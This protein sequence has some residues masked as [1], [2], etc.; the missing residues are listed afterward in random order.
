MDS[1]WIATLNWNRLIFC[2]YYELWNFCW[3]Y[4]MLLWTPSFP[5]HGFKISVP[6]LVLVVFWQLLRRNGQISSKSLFWKQR[7]QRTDNSKVIS[8]TLQLTLVLYI[9]KLAYVSTQLLSV[10]RSSINLQDI[11][12]IFCRYSMAFTNMF[13][14]FTISY[15]SLLLKEHVPRTQGC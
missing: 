1:T 9:F 6:L 2:F 8:K 5:I 12:G 15:D 4:I 14:R 10:T 11:G 7:T 3:S 13:C